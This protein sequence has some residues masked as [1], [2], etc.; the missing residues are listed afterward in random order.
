MISRVPFPTLDDVYLTLTQDEDSRMVVVTPDSRIDGVSFA[1]QMV[2]RTRGS[3]N[4]RNRVVT[5]VCKTC[6]RTGHVA[7]QCFRTIGYPPWWGDRPRNRDSTTPITECV[8]VGSRNKAPS[9]AH[10]VTTTPSTSH[11]AHAVVG[12][13]D[14]VGLS[15]LTDV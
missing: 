4:D 10:A 13:D 15:G 14:R 12:E 3:P 1:A 2:L 9:S 11:A 6:G 5:D 8:L 7:E